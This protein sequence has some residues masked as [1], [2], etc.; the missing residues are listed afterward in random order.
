MAYGM[1]PGMID[2]ET[3]EERRMRLLAEMNPFTPRAGMGEQGSIGSSGSA[4]GFMPQGMLSS[5][6]TFNTP[7][8]GTFVDPGAPPSAGPAW[9]DPGSDGPGTVY[10]DP[11]TPGIL[12]TKMGESSKPELDGIL[13]G[14]TRSAGGMDALAAAKNRDS[15]QSGPEVAAPGINLM[16]ANGSDRN[17]VPRS[18]DAP[19]NAPSIVAN[20]F[21]PTPAPASPAPPAGAPSSFPTPPRTTTPARQPRAIVEGGAPA[22]SPPPIAPGAPAAGQAASPRA[23]G[24]AILPPPQAAAVADGLS[25]TPGSPDAMNWLKENADLFIGIGAGLLSG[26]NIG[27]GILHGLKMANESKV[28]S[29]KEKELLRRNQTEQLQTATYAAM[30][31]QAYGDKV[32]PEQAIAIAQTPAMM[33]EVFKSQFPSE[34]W[35]QQGGQNGQPGYL[36]NAR[37][38]DIKSDPSR[39]GPDAATKETVDLTTPEERRAHGI[40]E[41]DKGLYKWSKETG[42]QAV[43]Q[44][45]MYPSPEEAAQTKANTARVESQTGMLDALAKK[46]MQAQGQVGLLNRLDELMGQIDTGAK[47]QALENFRKATGIALDANASKV[48]AASATAEKMALGLHESGTGTITDRDMESF[49]QQIPSLMGT[50]EGNRLVSETLHGI[51]EHHK[52]ATDIAAR[53]QTGKLSPEQATDAL[54]NLKDPFS[55]MREYQAARTP[56]ATTAAPGGAAAPAAGPTPSAAGVRIYD[57]RTRTFR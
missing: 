1:N 41:S 16:G 20:P 6:Q 45:K 5:G 36:R 22:I 12:S 14:G 53:W 11:P 26:K 44:A 57:P 42:L 19:A 17:N 34:Q 49:R 8:R 46:R 15:M 56:E 9:R 33:N 10:Q 43:G 3:P 38:G 18:P 51:A 37:T 48:Q 24:A 21:G 55:R 23:A 32:T 4:F 13:F 29:A 47:T 35:Q 2:E 30:V 52:D 31:K 27:E 50:P 7:E 25:R 28:A 54:L 39:P 40:P